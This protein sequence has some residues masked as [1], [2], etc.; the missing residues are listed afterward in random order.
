MVEV[1]TADSLKGLKGVINAWIV[2]NAPTA[3]LNASFNIVGS[4][5]EALL[6][7]EP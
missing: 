2:A 1:F 6:V 5:Y 3:V 4:S 7:Y